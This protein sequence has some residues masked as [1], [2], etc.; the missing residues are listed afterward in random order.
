MLTPFGKFCNK[1]RIDLEINQGEMAVALGI[2]NHLL[3][4]IEHG[5]KS[6]SSELLSNMQSVYQLSNSQFVEL[7]QAAV[8][9]PSTM[10]INVEELKPD[11]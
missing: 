1:L 2:S 10:K 8:D 3:S 11:D 7:C 4:C 6:I 5:K 9:S